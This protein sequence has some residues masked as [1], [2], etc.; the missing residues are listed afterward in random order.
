MKENGM[1]DVLV[2][3][4]GII[5]KDQVPALEEMGVSRVFGAGSST[6]DIIEYIVSQKGKTKVA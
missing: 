6:T 2:I 3:I 1:G 5:R 4:G